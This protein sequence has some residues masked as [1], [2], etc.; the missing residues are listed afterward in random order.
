MKKEKLENPTKKKNVVSHPKKEV[1]TQISDKDESIQNAILQER[2]RI[3]MDLHDGIIQSLYGIGLNLQNT[4]MHL[5]E[6]NQVTDERLHQ[7]IQ[8]LDAAIRNIR[9]YILNLRPRQLQ[10]EN[11]LVGM[12][13]LIREFQANTLVEVE[14]QGDEVDVEGLPA[15]NAMALFHIFQEA[16]ANVARHADATKVNVRV[17]R[18]DQRVMMRVSDDGTGFDSARVEQRIGHGLANMQTRAQAVGGGLE[19]ISIRKQ[20]TIILAWVPIN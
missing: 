14:Q 3:G 10:N 4:R 9:A 17:W 6:D 11:L 8:T 12:R 16:L 18:V 20:G 15:A 13:G 5:G 7:S 1:K 2:E 19:V